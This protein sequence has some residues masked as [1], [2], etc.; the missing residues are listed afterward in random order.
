MKPRLR[1][2]IYGTEGK[3]KTL[4]ESYLTCRYQK[5]ILNNNNNNNN[6]NNSSS[7]WE[8]IK[9]NGVPQG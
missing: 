5:V 9:K 6:N 8:L 1:V 7:K 3:F 2:E 4:F